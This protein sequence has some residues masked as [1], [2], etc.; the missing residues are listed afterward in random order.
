MTRN[1]ET[2]RHAIST[3]IDGSGV[4]QGHEMNC[5]WSGGHALDSRLVE[6]EVRCTSV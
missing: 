4:S 3:A 6:H 5:T 2:T 1:L